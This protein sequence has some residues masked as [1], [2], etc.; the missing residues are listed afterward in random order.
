MKPRCAL[1]GTLTRDAELRTSSKGN[2]YV[3]ANVRVEAFAK[4]S[5][6]EP[7]SVFTRVML[8]GDGATA[9]LV[10]ELRQGVDAYAE[11]NLEL[12]VWVD[13]QGDPWPSATLWAT[14]LQ[15]LGTFDAPT[16][17]TSTRPARPRAD[18]APHPADGLMPGEEV[19][20][21][22]G[23]ARDLGGGA[24]GASA[25]YDDDGIPY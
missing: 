16:S 21:R 5:T 19:L 25:G 23:R 18:A 15:T 11:G 6:G 24:T 14:E 12:G 1:V 3:L 8:F 10:A 7:V 4:R 9:E 2:P 13:K 17:S 20:S 22:S